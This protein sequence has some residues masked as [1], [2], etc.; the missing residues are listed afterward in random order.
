MA[1]LALLRTFVTV[2][3][4]GSIT[5]ASK[6]LR[7][8]QPAVSQH[9]R[10]LEAQVGHPLFVRTARGVTPTPH[11]ARL[12]AE[13]AAHIEALEAVAS[14]LRPEGRPGAATVHVGGPADVLAV[15]ALPALAEKTAGE[16]RIVGVP[17]VANELVEKLESG[18]LDVL[19]A[20]EKF[21]R[22]ALEYET[23]GAE[24]QV[25]VAAPRWHA[26]LVH[27]GKLQRAR[28]ADAPFLAFRSDAPL[29]KETLRRWRV[30]SPPHIAVEVPDQRA[31]VAMC[32][33]GAGL[34]IVPRS[35]AADAL[36]RGAVLSIEGPYAPPAQRL[37]VAT[38][39]GR[40][41]APHV[42]RCARALLD[43]LTGGAAAAPSHLEIE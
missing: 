13:I 40:R 18:E 34:A 10:A 7:I 21:A 19:V 11:A 16:L 39:T 27:R 24:P 28:L 41:R 31:L 4:A 30:E 6:Q 12:W 15:R 22:D 23:A 36:S 2:Y 29:V 33:A 5:G 20:T 35:V 8:G 3:R 9:V 17:G 42:D 26:R 43:A 32:E 38:R 25:V 14:T 37:W 1:D